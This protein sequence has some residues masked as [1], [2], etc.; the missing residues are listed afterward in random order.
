MH[1]FVSSAKGIWGKNFFFFLTLVLLCNFFVTYCSFEKPSAPSW[2]VVVSVPLI[3]EVYT[4]QELADEE[5]SIL[6]DSS[7]V[8]NFEFEEELDSYYVGDELTLEN[9]DEAFEL[10]LGSFT[11]E[12][13]GTDSSSVDLR[14][15]FSNADSLNGQMV[16]VSAFDFESE[17]KPFDY[18]GFSYAIVESGE[19]QFGVRNDLAV[20][21]GPPLTIEIWDQIADTLITSSTTSTQIDPASSVSFPLDLAGATLPNRL[22]VRMT[23]SSDGSS[24]NPV[25]VDASSTFEMTAEVGE[26]QVVEALAEIPSQIVRNEDDFEIDDSF[27]VADAR[28]EEGSIN[29]AIVGELPVDTWIVYELLDFIAPNGQALVDSFFVNRLTLVNRLIS[30]AGYSFQPADA[31]FGE[32]RTQFSWTAKTI[33]TGSDM[34][35][36]RASDKFDAEVNLSGVRFSQVSGK[37]AGREI[38]IDQ[39][40]IEFDVPADLDSI[41]FE[42]AQM[43]LHLNNRIN[44]PAT[45][46]FRIEGRNESGA[47]S[48]LD[49]NEPVQAA[50]APGVVRQSI[51]VLDQQNSN[52]NEFISILPSLMRVAG[53]VEL[54][55]PNWVGTVSEGDYIDGMVKITAPFAM[56]LPQQEVESD[57]SELEIDQDVKD[58]I[59][60]NIAS[61][62]FYAEISNHLPL[63]ASVEIFFSQDSSRVYDDPIL[64]VG[65]LDSDA[66]QVDG[67]GLVQSARTSD[68]SIDLNEDE[69]RTFLRSPLYAG[70]RVRTD[71]TQQQFIRVRSS[72]FI[73][74]RSYSRIKVKVNQD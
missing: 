70:V 15:I 66:A 61:G 16:I 7:G 39:Q 71:G 14:E 44:F 63:G 22:A 48:F 40:Q 49:V 20:P 21:L 74:I 72:D 32:Q 38:S 1:K 18:E 2:D 11:V 45:L 26:M 42:T 57:V 73:Q 37:L 12:S 51:I 36:V 17:K 69:M 35:L 65:P 59:I 41:F 3:T 68:I 64:R 67:N 46:D 13:P 52:I 4:M 60:E 6:V 47:V 9:V 27:V 53:N 43:E 29:L 23:G 50:L 31:D 5:S 58:D 55:D 19:I 24:G 34:A 10:T 28:I 54:G 33:A 56:R 25:Q 30:L 8:L 62:S